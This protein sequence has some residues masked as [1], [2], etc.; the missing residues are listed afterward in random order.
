M[1]YIELELEAVGRLARVQPSLGTVLALAGPDETRLVVCDRPGD[2]GSR[3]TCFDADG[4]REIRLDV[5]GFRVRLLADADG[6]QMLAIGEGEE[7]GILFDATGRVLRRYG[8]G[9][10]IVDACYDPDGNIVVLRSRPPLLD[11]YGPD[12]D[13]VEADP[14]LERIHESTA[15]HE[16]TMLV[17]QRDG[18]VWL[19][20]AE[21]FDVKGGI[22]CSLDA[23]RAFGAGRVCADLVGWDGILVLTEAG[24]LHALNSKGVRRTARLPDEA[25]RAHLGRGMSAVRD[26]FVTRDE[27][28]R[29][30]D[31]VGGAVLSF[32]ILSE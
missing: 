12:G 16:G 8:F 20:L 32:R 3:L 18:T 19:N 4:S 29:L 22:V 13:R 1:R 21:A 6:G 9:G 27:K 11:R 23:E 28:L 14:Q 30:V 24:R 25:I 10:G 7:D 26:V 2:G 17:I 15:Q 5:P 31:T